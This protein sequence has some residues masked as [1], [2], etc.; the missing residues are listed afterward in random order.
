MTRDNNVNARKAQIPCGRI[1]EIGGDLEWL[2]Q[3]LETVAFGE[4]GLVFVVHD[5]KIVRVK[6]VT[7]EC[8]LATRG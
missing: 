5:G 7:E 6:K 2:S 8:H 3:S 1:Q 4:V